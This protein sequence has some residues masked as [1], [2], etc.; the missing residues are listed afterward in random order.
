MR[1]NRL[2]SDEERQGIVEL[3]KCGVKVRHIMEKYGCCRKTVYDVVNRALV[4]PV[5]YRRTKHSIVY[6]NIERWMIENNMSIRSL[7]KLC[8]KSHV[9]LWRNLVGETS[10]QLETCTQICNATG[11]TFEEAFQRA[12]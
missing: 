7:S 12:E 11:L 10:P 1:M 2:L 5:C 8:G 4:T 6:P 3:Y 9:C